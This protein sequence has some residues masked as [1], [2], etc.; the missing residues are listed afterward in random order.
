MI[1]VGSRDARKGLG[2]G[3]DSGGEM[4]E[5]E[6]EEGE[7]C[8]YQNDDDSTIDPD[9][10]LSY[11]DDK[12]QDVL[13]HFQKDFEGGVSAENLGA[14]FGGYGS[15]LP[16]YQRSP[17]WS[18][19][20]SPPK[21]HDYST[22]KSP[23]NLHLEG[24]RHNS[25][26]PS[27][28]SLSARH[29][30]S[31]TNAA[32]LPLLRSSNND[33]SKRDIGMSSAHCAEESNSRCELVKNC[34]Q[35]SDQKTLKVRIKV[36]SDN[37]STQKN[38]EIYS[39][40]G[41]DISP[42]SS[43]NESPT[44]SEGFSHEPLDAPE[45]SPTSILQIMTSFPVHGNLLLSPL[46]DD[47][48]YMTEKEKLKGEIKPRRVIK[49]SQER[50]N[51]FDSARGND[52]VLGG[53][54][55][56]P[57][58]RNAFSVELK[59]H[60]D[61]GTQNGIGVPLK[62][63]TDI[64]TLACEELVANTLKLPL[65]SN[66][67]S[68]VANPDKGT[69]R[70]AN[71]SMVANKVKEES[72]SDLAKVETLEG[73]PNQEIGLVEK[74]NGKAVS[75]VKVWEEKKA[76]FRNDI[77]AYPRKDG[78]F[79]VEKADGF[80]KDDSN[81]SKAR[82]AQSAEPIDPLEQ[83]ASKRA[84]SHDEDNKQLVTGKEHSSLGGKKKSKGSQ[85]AEVPKDSSRMDSALGPKNRKSTYANN[86]LSKGEV[87]DSKLQKDYGKARNTY[88]D[89]FGDIELE[90][91]DNDVDS[92]DM[93]S[94]DRPED[95]EAVEKNTFA[96]NST[97]KERLNGKKMDKPSI[98]EACSKAPLSAA[99]I[100]RNG[101]ISDAASGT[102]GPH[103]K[104]DWVCCDKCQKWR[105]LPRGTNPDSLPEK[106]LCSMLD[107]LPGMNRCIFSEEET[108][109]A[110]IASYQ[111][112]ALESQNNQHGYPGGVLPRLSMTD[113]SR[114]DQNQPNL[115]FQ[116]V[117]S[118]GKKKNGIKDE[119]AAMNQDGPAQFSN[120]TK[121]KL[122]ASVRSRSLNGVNHSPSANEIESQHLSK[123]RVVEKHRHKQ[124]DK[125]RLLEHHSDGG[126]IRSSKSKSKRDTDQDCFRVSKKAKVD[127]MHRTDED[128]MPN[129]DRPVGKGGPSSSNGLS[130]NAS[131]RDRQ[132][133]EDHPS[134]DRKWEANN[135]SKGPLSNPKDQVLVTSDGGSPHMEKID[136]KEV[137]RKRKTNGSQD[138]HVYTTSLLSN[139]QVHDRRDFLEE[140]SE[141]DHRR[142]KKARVS[143]S[144]GKETS[145]SKSSGGAAK[146]GGSTKDQQLGPD[147]G[148][149]LVDLG[150][151]QPSQAATSSSSK[152]SGSHK[153]QTS[154]KEVKGSP[155]ESVSSSPLRFLNPDKSASTR[156]SLEGKDD[157]G[158]A[159][160]FATGTPRRCSDGEDDRGSN[161]SGT[162]RKDE[163]FAAHRGSLE[164]SVLDFQERNMVHLA[165]SEAKI[166]IVHSPEISNRHFANGGTDTLGN[167]TQYPCKPQTSDQCHNEER[168][169]D[170]QYHANVSR[171][172]KSGKGSSSRSKE[173]NGASQS[174]PDKGKVKI[175]DPCHEYTDH[176]PYEEKSRAGKNRVQEKSRVGSDRVE[177]NF[178][179]EKVS[180]GKVAAENSKRESRSKFGGDDGLDVKVDALS[181]QDQKQNLRLD[182][183]ERSSKKYLSNKTDRIEVSGR[184]KSHS[185]PPSGRGQNETVT[186]SV[187]LVPGSQKENGAN[188]LLIDASKADDAL[189]A[190]KNIKKS[191][192]QNGNQP[193]KARHPTTNGHRVRD[194]DAP[195]PVRRESSSQA[196]T[197]AVKEAK[198]LKHL[199]DR[200][201][202]SG[203]NSESTGLYFQ[204]A[205]KF[206]H[207]A[208]LLESSNS[209]S[210][211]QS[212]M[213][214][215]MQM[216]S[217]TAKLC[218][219][220][221]H[222]YEKS[223]DMAAAALA[224][225]CTEVAYMRVIYSSHNS[226]SRDR[227][228]LQATLQIVQPG[229]SPSSS[230][231]DVDNLNNP[232]AVD[233]VPLSKGVSSPQVAGNHVTATRNRP[234][235]VRLLNFAQDVNYA[236]EASR[237]SR[238]AF[239]A[240]N[241][242]MEEAQHREGLTS[243]KR[244]LD[245]NFQ[246]VEGLLRLTETHRNTNATYYTGVNKWSNRGISISISI[247]F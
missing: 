188:S 12:L 229:E 3:F 241:P 2:L 166:Q 218:E 32:L 199:A 99:P 168:G 158:D 63:E 34:A 65:L 121:K 220:C 93:L 42:S 216:Y 196:A 131:A 214:Q 242:R 107:W 202:N 6:L 28:A 185:L 209:E 226:A 87:E 33:S 222:E 210:A 13:G 109:A 81:V 119:S 138:T 228:E 128:W 64:D 157:S 122:P 175:S 247:S 149:N 233:K 17:V 173:N 46:P 27:S 39:G 231:S 194:V 84:T 18:R 142:E 134:K 113:G 161:R 163:T 240:A 195:S 83:K 66:S 23:N 57:F 98:S 21:N 129:H 123:S 243:V 92:A 9:V 133:Y 54:K 88:R 183:D 152:V 35:P 239:A 10:A 144:E 160:L 59:N 68:N 181:S 97:S 73:L 192:N 139:N 75:D 198:D 208:S 204:A 236:M 41:L 85:S 172:R 117:P 147:I 50:S 110:L 217:S 67:Y 5:N 191:E 120:S 52:K 151:V 227:H 45:E 72:F 47:L 91:G 180:A 155:V 125:N 103:D 159:G 22:P 24:G 74:P 82:K 190:P 137:A 126:E 118:G 143:N 95:F 100:N 115:G 235:F 106:W 36:G 164:S 11:L 193:I 111:F 223:K 145:V 78:N 1:S 25:V 219:F 197:N 104:E 150:S 60:I 61:K 130:V 211:K 200:L 15:F 230:A 213:I 19:P 167:G 90:Q 171:P 162:V 55:L 237:K 179:G 4:E 114:F 156:R 184:G 146:K 37:L 182:R 29:G 234:S 206:L 189:K 148:S 187:H 48:I 43:L 186:H 53:K 38:A 76:N 127:G 203:S 174:D 212:E 62:K 112:P 31:S 207:G 136:D 79:K 58:E 245:F 132:K 224:Y 215:S 71:N 221:A 178:V 70:A 140:T 49:S 80:A 205:L 40:L 244:A 7:A 135:S 77:S 201:K 238:S 169:N 86:Y 102:A 154:L 177:K 124:K 153:N 141:N 51:G 56:K 165:G 16:T 108:T 69:A 116:A 94:I 225:K 246:D 105:L 232:T 44:D 101:L 96:S 170:K 20:R 89:F 176:T 8:S 14:K 26:V 30:P